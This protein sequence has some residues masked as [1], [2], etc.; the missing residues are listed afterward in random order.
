MALD[1][2]AQ[3][4]QEGPNENWSQSLIKT[5]VDGSA[6]TNGRKLEKK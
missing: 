4:D 5:A 6:P 3:V 1:S 2:V